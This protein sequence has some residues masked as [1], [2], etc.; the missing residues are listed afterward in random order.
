MSA[1]TFSYHT[2]LDYATLERE[3]TFTSTVA[4]WLLNNNENYL[5]GKEGFKKHC[6]WASSV[7][8]ICLFLMY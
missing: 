7:H 4:Y 8:N 1:N 3:S 6:L 2:D 5:T